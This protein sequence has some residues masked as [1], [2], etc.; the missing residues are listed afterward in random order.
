ML[1]CGNQQEDEEKNPISFSRGATRSWG[2]TISGQSISTSGSAGSPSSRSEP[3]MVPPAVC[4]NTSVQLNQMDSQGDDAV[5]Q[6]A[7]GSKKKKRGARAVGNDKGGRG[8]RQFSM[9]VC[10][11]VESKGRTTY[12]EVADELVAEFTDPSSSLA[13]PDQQQYDE[14][15]IRRRVYDALNVLMAMDIISKD[16]KEIQWK[17]LPRTSLNDVEELKAERIGLRNRIEK[18]TAYLKEL[19]DQFI[20]L[21][22]LVQRNE[23]LYGSGNAPS[24]G[25]TLPFILV[26]TRPHATVEVE[27]SE[28]MQL[29]HF[30][31][32]STP[33][34]LHDD[35]YV[36]KAMRSREN[37]QNDTP[38]ESTS[39]GG[40]SSRIP[41]LY[42]HH[43][44]PHSSRSNT[45]GK[46]PNSPRVPGILKA[47]RVKH[48]Q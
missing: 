41:S 1:I 43:H 48:E 45:I 27:I 44:I 39:N 28:D 7:F 20:D 22:N 6:G 5:S 14:K 4:D 35:A 47:T 29:V 2:T 11:K 16:K 33:F 25:V 12:N 37:E 17:G 19:E 31:F 38:H 23:Q 3:T 15:N 8:L 34:E 24:G 18:K 9:K 42:Q 32:N 40:E 36:L 21:K 26:Q 46:W 30:D 13:S 10:E